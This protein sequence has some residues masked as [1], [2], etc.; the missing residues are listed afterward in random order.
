MDGLS[1]SVGTLTMRVPKVVT[2]GTR[3][4][5]VRDQSIRSNRDIP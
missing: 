1:F 5:G 2:A 3:D 4:D